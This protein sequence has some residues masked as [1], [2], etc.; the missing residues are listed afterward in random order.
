MADFPSGGF[1]SLKE[2][3]DYVLGDSPFPIAGSYSGIWNP[4]EASRAL[5]FGRWPAIGVGNAG[6]LYATSYLAATGGSLIEVSTTGSINTALDNASDGDAILLKTAGTYSVT[7]TTT[8]AY[9]SDPWRAKNVLIVGDVDDAGDIT[10]II[11]K[12]SP[13]GMHLFAGGSTTHNP[14]IYKQMAFLTAF[15]NETSTTSY[16]N[17]LVAQVATSGPA[18]GRMVNCIHNSNTG[19]ISWIYNNSL[20]TTIDVEFVRCTF[21]N[22]GTWYAKYSGSNDVITVSNTLFS[23]ATVA[24]YVDGGFNVTSATVNNTTGSYDTGTYSTAGHLFIPNTDVVE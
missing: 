4:N 9:G 19:G 6:S 7:C 23:G 13:R 15:K 24:N 14:S 8:D 20:L 10:L 5:S 1:W 17:A 18:Q 16:I 12:G 22:Y 11:S 21:I 2:H 3:R